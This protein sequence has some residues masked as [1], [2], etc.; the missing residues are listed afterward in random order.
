MTAE[1]LNYPLRGRCDCGELVYVLE[2]PPMVVHCCQYVFAS[3]L[4]MV[5]AKSY[6]CRWCQRQTGSSFALHAMVEADKL[7]VLSG[8]IEL[9]TVASPSGA[10]QTITRCSTCHF[11]VWSIYLS[12]G[13]EAD[14]LRIL[15]VGTL[16]N[17]DCCPPTY[18][19][20]TRFKQPWIKLSDDIPAF[21]DF[22]NKQ[23]YWPK[24]QLERRKKALEV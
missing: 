4:S 9:T 22:Y 23:E 21:V 3:Q 5:N 8:E 7:R 24:E 16:D 6:S 17:P 18:H 14:V 10:G 20:Y 15:D 2:V 12:L 13:P 1:N 11:A 19:I